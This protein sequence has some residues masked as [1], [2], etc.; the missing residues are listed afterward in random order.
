MEFPVTTP[1][2][3]YYAVMF[4]ATLTGVDMDE[5]V[6]LAG[7][8]LA[9][10]GTIA[11]FLGEEALRTDDRGLTI[12]YW[13]D[14]DSIRAWMADA[15]HIAARKLGKEK[16]YRYFVIRVAKVERAYDFGAR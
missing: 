11:G 1:D 12:S 10:A 8:L 5:Y 15:E 14:L 7:A 13:R 6:Q 2:P 9:K 3:P 16:W 4:S